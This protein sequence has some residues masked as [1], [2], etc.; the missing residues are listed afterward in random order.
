MNP[1]QAALVDILLETLATLDAPDA[2]GDGGCL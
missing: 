2:A 1:A